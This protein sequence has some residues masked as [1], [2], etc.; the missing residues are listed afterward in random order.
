[1]IQVLKFKHHKGKTTV[2]YKAVGE[3]HNTPVN[4]G[5]T[6]I[7]LQRELHEALHALRGAVASWAEVPHSKDH[8]VIPYSF[9]FKWNTTLVSVTAHAMRSMKRSS[10]PLNQ[11][12]NAKLVPN[13]SGDGKLDMMTGDEEG[14]VNNLLDQ[15][16]KWIEALPVEEPNLFNQKPLAEEEA[17]LVA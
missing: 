8:P 16:V 7:P 9:A 17:E 6:E 14:L 15:V 1:M 10:N 13:G 4:I 5:P 3:P 12:C 2:Q 11:P